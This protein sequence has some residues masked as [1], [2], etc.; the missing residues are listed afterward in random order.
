MNNTEKRFYTP[1]FSETASVSVVAKASPPFRMVS[2]LTNDPSSRKN[3]STS[4]IH[5]GQFKSL[6]D[7]QRQP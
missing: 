6:S 5:H 7:L 2:K 1:Q 3:Y 4:T